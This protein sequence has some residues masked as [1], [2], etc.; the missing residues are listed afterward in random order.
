MNKINN[1]KELQATKAKG[2]QLLY[3]EKIKIMVGMATCGISAGADKV[4]QALAGSIA[5]NGYDVV[6]VKTGCIGYCQREPLVDVVYPGKVRLSYQGMDP[7]KAAELMEAIAAGEILDKYLL[8][9]IDQDEFLIEGKTR[10]YANPHPP[11]LP[12]ETPRYEELPFFRKQVKISLRNCGFINPENIEEYI[13]RG[14]YQALHQALTKMTPE[15]VIAQVKDSGLRGRGGAGFPTGQKWDF[16]RQAPGDQKFVICNADEGDPGAFM[17]RG[18]LEGDPHAV[19]E[20]MTIGAYAMG[21]S[22]GY[23]YCRAEYPL[24]IQRL[25]TAIAQAEARGLLGKGIFGTDFSFRLEIREGAGAFVCGEET[26]LI[27][28]IEGRVGEPRPRPPFPAQSGLWGQPTN[29]NNVKTWSHIAPIIARGAQWYASMGTEKSKGTTVFS[30]V[31][32]VKNSGLV[33]V[34][35]GITLR[36][37]IFEL[38]GGIA[39]DRAFKAV[40]TGGPSGGCIPAEFLDTPVDYES[41]AALGSI[42]GSGGMIVMDDRDCMVNVARYFLDFTKDE[43]CGK[44]TPCREGTLRLMEKLTDITRGEG[45]EEDL[46]RL[47]R[48]SGLIKKTALCGLGATAPNPVLSTLRYFKDEYLAHIVDKQCHS[49]VCQRLSPSPCQSGCPAGIDVPSYVALIGQGRYAEALELIREDN[50]LVS[51]CGYVCPAPCEG[52][53]RRGGADQPLAIKTLKRFVADFAREQGYTGPEAN[54][55][56]DEKVA[57]IGSGPAGLTAAYYLAKEGYPVTVFEATEALGGM[58]RLGIPRFRLPREVFDFD[59]ENIAR[60]GVTFQTNTRIG[61]DLTLD[62]LKQQG[63][64]AVFLGTGAHQEVRLGIKGEDLEGVWPGVEFLKRMALGE[65]IP[66]GERVAIIGGGNVATDA[67]RTAIRLGCGVTVLL[68]RRTEKE[69]PA[70]LEEVLQAKEEGVDCRFLLQ[71]VEFLG[72][73]R[74]RKILL[75]NMKLGKPDVSGRRRPIPIP[76]SEWTMEVDTVIK[77]VGQIPTP[78]KITLEGTDLQLTPG[79]SIQVDPVSLAT[80]LPGVFA[81]GDNVTGSASVVE[82]VKAGKQAARSIQRYLHGEPLEKKPRIPIPRMRLEPLEISEEERAAIKPLMP[83]R[84]RALDRIRDFALVELDLEKSQYQREACRC[85]RCDLGD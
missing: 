15:E 49:L 77:A 58:L 63:F 73:G 67:A 47:T 66:L 28:S 35:L 4:F 45:Q 17:D 8:C 78:V 55:F 11:A 48:W 75:Q 62:D 74:V 30:L 44:C 81:G 52:K 70:Y 80:N 10:P 40:Q 83:R 37:M 20:G 82:A 34:P 22:E 51:V 85:L 69:M 6:L 43:S 79:G 56:R 18:I 65:E 33:E 32:K 31:G 72:D 38:G 36:E 61:V 27:A 24:A 9:R 23:V 13:A 39:G 29:I 12:V 3:P 16:C 25:K 50:P 5:E 54:I 46:E 57:V 41:L 53:C 19:L 64:Q 1:L 84:R 21:A 26:A 76:D 42:M 60:Q 14:G 2:M 68:Y 71:P 7:D 59:L